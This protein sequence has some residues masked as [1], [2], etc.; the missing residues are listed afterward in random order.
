MK[1]RKIN[2]KSNIIGTNIQKY[3]LK[4]NLSL[5]QLSDKLSLIGVNLYHSD[6]F[7]IEN[8]TRLVKDF[9]LKAICMVLD[10]TFEQIFEDTDKDFLI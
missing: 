7:D 2:G 8:H 3:R 6:I 9:E 10:I 5:R 1:S 4:R